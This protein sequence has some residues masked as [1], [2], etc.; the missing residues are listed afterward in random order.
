MQV[1]TP[2][3]KFEFVVPANAAAGQRMTVTL[4][5]RAGYVPPPTGVPIMKIL[6]TEVGGVRLHLKPSNT[7]G[8]AGV[9]PY[10]TSGSF[11][12]KSTSAAVQVH[13]TPRLRSSTG[14]RTR[15]VKRAPK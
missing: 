9:Q 12:A 4:P 11:P 7:T 15:E 13:G 6:V 14:D 1:T 5:G 10:N 2:L 8:Y 3:G